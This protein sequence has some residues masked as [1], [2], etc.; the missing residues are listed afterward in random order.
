MSCPALAV[1]WIPPSRCKTKNDMTPLCR[2]LRNIIIRRS[3]SLVAPTRYL[4]ENKSSPTQLISTRFQ[5][6]KTYLQLVST[7]SSNCVYLQSTSTHTSL[8]RLQLT[9]LHPPA[10]LQV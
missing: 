7:H 6:V 4:K 9:H 8:T 1:N 2:S 10:S 3:L 5:R